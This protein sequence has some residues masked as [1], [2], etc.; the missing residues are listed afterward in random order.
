MCKKNF[1]FIVMLSLLLS[2]CSIS[3]PGTNN[4]PETIPQTISRR[5]ILDLICGTTNDCLQEVC[6]ELDKCPIITA[7]SQPVV[8][9]FI[10]TYSKC[11]GCNTPDFPT[12][13]GIGKCIE[14][15]ILERTSELEVRFQVSKN[16]DFRYANPEEV[17]ISVSVDSQ[18][19]R[20]NQI[21]PAIDF[22]QD[23]NFC[24]T[25]SDCRCLAGSGVP[26]I[27][28]NNVFYA[29]LNWAGYYKDK[30]CGCV[31]SKCVVKDK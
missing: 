1:I 25:E 7:L 12:A 27:G 18:N 24:K 8:F 11:E 29:P 10:A 9:N 14:Y 30:E 23:S 28:A 4:D 31:R 17:K 16:C 19:W 2:G 22:I 26:L 20:I 3:P 13:V 21:T 6:P 15:E 5:N